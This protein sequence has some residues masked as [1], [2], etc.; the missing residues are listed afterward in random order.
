MKNKFILLILSSCTLLFSCQKEVSN[1]NGG[2]GNSGNNGTLLVKSVFKSGSDSSQTLYAYDGSKRLASVSNSGVDA[3]TPYTNQINLTRNSGGVIQK[4][5]VK[6]D[7]FAQYG[8]DSLLYNVA[9]DAGTSRYKYKVFALNIGFAL[10]KDSVAYEYDAAGK[11]VKEREFIDDGTAGGYEEIAKTEYTYSGNNIGTAKYFT[12]D[13]PTNT[14]TLDETDTFEYD[15]KTNALQLGNEAIVIGDV[16][17]YG[18]NNVSKQTID[19]PADPTSNQTRT[20]T[21]T[22]NSNNRPIT[23][24][25]VT[26][27]GGG[28]ATAS[29]TYQ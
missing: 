14:Y 24:T 19:V 7:Q 21:Y 4:M 13:V 10:L 25:F 11:I 2:G 12:Y 23:A 16:T 22:Y 6:S 3:G 27:P 20:T 28:S 5:S 15:A 8:I 1:E 18:P 9:Y 26:T 29:F 17:F